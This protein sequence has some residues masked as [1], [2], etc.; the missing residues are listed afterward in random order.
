MKF[1]G[2]INVPLFGLLTM[3]Y[4]SNLFPEWVPFCKES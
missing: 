4:E 1:E 2:E 3:I